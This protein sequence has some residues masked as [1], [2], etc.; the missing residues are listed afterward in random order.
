[1]SSIQELATI[2]KQQSYVLKRLSTTEK[3]SILLRIHDE[4]LQ[5]RE[6][7]LS[8]NSKDVENQDS[9]P[10]LKKRLILNSKFDDLLL[11]VKQVIELEDPN[12]KVLMARALSDD[13]LDLYRVS[14]PIG[15]ILII[16]EARPEVVVQIICLALKSGNGCILKGGKEA[17]HSNK[18]LFDCI[19]KALPVELK[20]AFQ[21]VHTRQDISELLQLDSIDLVIPRGSNQLVQYCKDNTR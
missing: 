16:F 20:G 10:Q 6:T 1:M 9:K 4:L 18:I 14:C 15:V 21:L 13:G 3:N 2:T 11:G 17:F 5:N 12:N 7:I 19:Q 8:E